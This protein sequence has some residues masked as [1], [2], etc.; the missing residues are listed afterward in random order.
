M[1][2][3]AIFTGDE[4]HLSIAQAIA[5]ALETK[6]TVK[7]FFHRG[8]ELDLYAYAYRYLPAAYG[9]IYNLSRN[10]AVSPVDSLGM[11]ILS[12]NRKQAIHKFLAETKPDLCLSTYWLFAPILAEYRNKT[13]IP[14]INVLS[15]PWTIHPAGIS[16]EADLQLGFDLK[17]ISQANKF[18]PLVNNQSVGWFVRPEFQPLK[19]SQKLLRRDLN[20]ADMF[21][22]LV[23]SGSEG[24]N[25]VLKLIPAL[26]APPQ[27][28]QVVIACGHN[29]Q[30]LAFT[31]QLARFLQSLNSPIKL[32][33]LPF[34]TEIAK[35]IQAA[36]LIVGKAGPNSLFETIAV[37]KPFVA[38]AHIPGQEDGNLDLIKHYQLGFVEENPLKIKAL[39]TKLIKSPK[40]LTKLQPKIQ[41]MAELNAAASAKLAKLVQGLFKKNL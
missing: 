24:S 19:G 12:A 28:I 18:A 7:I 36:D 37:Q 13:G 27:P 22:I 9:A 2:T 38:I 41:A 5:A 26:I 29:R 32:V 21:T 14:F 4:G 35:Y 25:M 39:L 11:K 23:N 31:K 6:Y 1:R 10:N 20:L 3:I 16:L 17:A 15:D 8:V 40:Q 33:T 30:L 34:T